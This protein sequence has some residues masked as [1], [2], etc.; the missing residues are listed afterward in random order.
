MLCSLRHYYQFDTPT[1]AIPASLV[2]STSAI[3]YKDNFISLYI[4]IKA[5]QLLC[6]IGL[7]KKIIPNI[8][9]FQ[10]ILY[11]TATAT[12]FH[13]AQFKATALRSSYWKFLFSLSGSRVALFNR[14]IL[15]KFGM[16]SSKAL[17]ATLLTT[18]TLGKPLLWPLA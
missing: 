6:Y 17:K 7:E 12:L 13:A 8:K 18:N 11:A 10:V 2:A 16:E 5:L 9:N 14:E 1:F 15:E 4:L 3:V